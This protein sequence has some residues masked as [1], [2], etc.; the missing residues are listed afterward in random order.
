MRTKKREDER[1]N[2]AINY[3]RNDFDRSDSLSDD[4]EVAFV[5]GAEWADRT[6]LEKIKEWFSEK[7]LDKFTEEMLELHISEVVPPIPL[8]KEFLKKEG[9]TI[10]EKWA[11]RG[12]LKYG[13]FF[14]WYFEDDAAGMHRKHDIEIFHDGRH[15]H[16]NCEY[17][18][19]YKRFLKLM[20]IDKYN[21]S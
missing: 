9:F 20:E 7:C 14:V 17:V 5:K 12:N 8:T 13:R 16:L 21:I 11:E 1:F 15:I 6:M 10:K 4:I 19:Q 3:R 2:A 18:H